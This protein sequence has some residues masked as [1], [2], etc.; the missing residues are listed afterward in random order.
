ML[1][2]AGVDV[3][4]IDIANTIGKEKVITLDRMADLALDLSMAPELV[5]R[6]LGDLLL[7]SPLFLYETPDGELRAFVPGPDGPLICL[8]PSTGLELNPPPPG[9]A[10]RALVFSR[11]I[12]TNTP[13]Q[14][15]KSTW[16]K[17]ARE[18]AGRVPLVVVSLTAI[19]NVMGLALPLFTLAVYDQVLAAGNVSILLFLVSGLAL[20]IVADLILRMLRSATLA[21][22][23]ALIDLK[24]SMH[25]V[26]RILR[27]PSA[28]KAATGRQGLGRLRDLD[29]VRDAFT[30]P[31]IVA[32]AEAPFSVLYILVLFI[33]GG[34]LAIVPAVTL[35][36]GAFS[37]LLFA[38]PK[39]RRAQASLHQAEDYG[40][41][42]DDIAK[43]FDAVK[44]E[45]AGGSW[46]RRFND[47]SVR[48]AEAELFRQ[49]SL[50]VAQTCS[51]ALVSVTV[52]ATMG[53]GALLAI[54]GN[55][56]IGA[57]IA[58]VAL[59]WRLAS[60]LASL[61]VARLRWPEIK[62]KLD[63]CNAMIAAEVDSR[64]VDGLGGRGRG[65]SG[66]VSFSSVMRTHQ[67]GS[68]PAIRN[69][70]VDIKPGELIAVVGHG[71][72]GKSTFLDLIAGV[73]EP[74]FGTV[75]IDGINPH[76]V[77]R[78][79]LRQSVGYLSREHGAMPISIADFLELG[80]D[81]DLYRTP[82][83]ICTRLAIQE[84]IDNLPRG[85]ETPM[86]DLDAAGGL[87]RAIA[88]ARILNTDASLYLFDEPDASST[89]SRQTF[90]AEI[91]KRRGDATIFVA[92]HEPEYVAA[93]D[94]VL[95]FHQGSLIRDCS[96]SDILR[97]NKAPQQ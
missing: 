64:L 54:E 19:S 88:L 91:E 32:L 18:A 70:S 11:T 92:T 44:L 48:L 4:P 29:T 73:I 66:R 5:R 93:V 87:S 37:I 52:I 68:L 49:S 17:L 72:A 94:R 65:M 69:V 3:T 50:Q 16:V 2:F 21:R 15:D 51:G 80:I 40:I 57:L 58:S 13:R 96:P 67:R 31:S 46:M 22:A 77:S 36:V 74:Q 90:L 14:T 27:S 39:V 53:A 84:A 63:A 7:E 55:L 95:V 75:T 43:R 61:I 59:V 35:M 56:S 89:L 28:A 82:R 10:G 30:G 9:E 47:A 26:A 71:G 76:Q 25:L 23:T 38:G 8:D 24:T 41:I 20:G 79:V 42:C 62:E 83:E 33:I 86:S 6:K 60:P 85:L 34:W 1:H 78:S 45:G 97:T 81:S 12:L